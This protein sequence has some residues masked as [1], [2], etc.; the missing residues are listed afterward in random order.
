MD[1]QAQPI[2][3]S[4]RGEGGAKLQSEN[5]PS[6]FGLPRKPSKSIERHERNL[7]G[8]EDLPDVRGGALVG[9][10]GYAENGDVRE[11]GGEC[12]ERH[13]DGQESGGTPDRRS[14]QRSLRR[15]ETSRRKHLY[16]TKL[17]PAQD[18]LQ[19]SSDAG[20]NLLVET[21]FCASGG[22]NSSADWV[23]W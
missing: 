23:R 1:L 10:A 14:V 17:V 7:P 6:A 20:T 2:D 21:A 13:G 16:N 9:L 19:A 15:R 5:E 3:G 11:H 18:V 22:E 8:H 12:G 4:K